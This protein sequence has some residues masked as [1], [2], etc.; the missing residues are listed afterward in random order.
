MPPPSE[1]EAVEILDGVRERY[2]SFHQVRYTDDALEAAVYQSHRYIPDRFLPDKAIDVIDEAGARVKLRVRREQGNLADWN[3]MNEWSRSYDET[4][5][6]RETS[7]DA[8]V[9]AEVTRDDVEEVIARWTGIPVTSLKEEETQKL[10]RIESRAAH[11]RRF[12]APGYLGAGPCHPP[13]AR[14]LEE[15]A[16]ARR[17]VPVSRSDRR[18][19]D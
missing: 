8:L 4:S 16:A 14:R 13:L 12:S 1:A 5:S 17:L 11:A 19:Q 10:L 2:E 7:E 6:V 3:Q 18:R 9:S 15:S